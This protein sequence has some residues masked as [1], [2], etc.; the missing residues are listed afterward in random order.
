MEVTSND[1]VLANTGA[2]SI[3]AIKR[4][5]TPA[6]KPAP[7]PAKEP[8]QLQGDLV[9]R[10][11]QLIQMFQHHMQ[12]QQKFWAFAKAAHIWEKMMFK[13]NFSKKLM[14]SPVFILHP[15][16][17]TSTEPAAPSQV[18]SP[19]EQTEEEIETEPTPPPSKKAKA[20]STSRKGKEKM[21]EHA[22]LESEFEA[23]S[24]PLPL[25][26]AKVASSAKKGKKKMTTAE[27]SHFYSSSSK[28][29]HI[30]PSPAVQKQKSKAPTEE[31]PTEENVVASDSEVA[32]TK[33]V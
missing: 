29:E 21:P 2:I 24:S 30:A 13:L 20:A 6:A 33:E 26:K 11:E 23:T 14:N 27:I 25:K 5:S 1:E 28:E 10:V 17:P 32:I 8:S 15:Y 22:Q 16:V 18:S 12:H 7:S 3:A 19:A 31:P 4:F 9:E